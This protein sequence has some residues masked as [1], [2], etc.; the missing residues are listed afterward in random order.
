M[1]LLRSLSMHFERFYL[2]VRTRLWDIIEDLITLMIFS[3]ILID[4]AHAL[5]SLESSA[6]VYDYGWIILAFSFSYG[7]FC[8]ALPNFKSIEE[9]VGEY[10]NDQ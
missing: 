9:R 3:A 4:I 10:F 7:G 5:F 2:R 8:L 1:S 6:N